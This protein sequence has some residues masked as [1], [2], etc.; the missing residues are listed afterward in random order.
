MKSLSKTIWLS[1]SAPPVVLEGQGLVWTD[2]TRQRSQPATR[3][4]AFLLNLVPDFP[5]LLQFVLNHLPL[6]LPDWAMQQSHGHPRF[7]R[8][9]HCR[10][11]SLFATLSSSDFWVFCWE[12]E[13]EREETE[14]ERSPVLWPIFF[15]SPCCCIR[16][17][18]ECFVSFFLFSSRTHQM[19]QP[20]SPGDEDSVLRCSPG[21]ASLHFCRS[22]HTHTSSLKRAT[23]GISVSTCS[24]PSCPR[25]HQGRAHQQ[26]L[27]VSEE[28]CSSKSLVYSLFFQGQLF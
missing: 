15:L 16:G 27:W 17:R 9:R 8:G 2:P 7:Q 25:S 23:L 21:Q 5:A 1:A 13:T 14:R 19:W 20:D 24:I 18:C 6:P 11:C 12:R 26:R 3:L 22:A 4:Q 10:G 28:R